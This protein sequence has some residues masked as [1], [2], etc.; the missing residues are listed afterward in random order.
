MVKHRRFSDKPKEDS[1]QKETELQEKTISAEKTPLDLKTILLSG[2]KYAYII[3]AVALLSGIFTPLTLGIEIENVIF[4]MLSIFL[5]LGGGI[6]IF[7]GIKYQK[8]TTIMVCGGLG[9]MIGS[10]LLI[11]ESTNHPIL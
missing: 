1:N 3:A 6:V 10:V 8:F 5:G 2:T 4:G 9:M 11:Y 7:L